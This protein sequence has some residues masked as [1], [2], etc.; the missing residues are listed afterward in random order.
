MV[1]VVVFP[2]ALF[3]SQRIHALGTTERS[4]FTTCPMVKILTLDF[5]QLGHL[6][7][8]KEKMTAWKK[9]TMLET[10]HFDEPHPTMSTRAL[11]Q[12]MEASTQDLA[13]QSW[14]ISPVIAK[15]VPTHVQAASCYILLT[16]PLTGPWLNQSKMTTTLAAR[17]ARA[18]ATP[19]WPKRA[20]SRQCSWEKR[21]GS[22]PDLS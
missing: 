5:C 12:E 9:L 17:P 6:N 19:V 7:N 3:T 22:K 21:L 14:C 15:W 18:F 8:K 13:L 1:Q 11:I 16:G 20:F 2:S 10:K 4:H